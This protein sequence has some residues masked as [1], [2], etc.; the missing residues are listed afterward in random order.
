MSPHIFNSH[1]ANYRFSS[2]DKRIMPLAKIMTVN[3]P[4]KNILIVFI[5]LIMSNPTHC[6][7]CKKIPGLMS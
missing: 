5:F 4:L 2:L 3:F 7:I 1:S 6:E